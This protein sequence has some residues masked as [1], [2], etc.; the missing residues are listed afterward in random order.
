MNS[1]KRASRV[2]GTMHQS[3]HF[4]VAT[5][6][7]AAEIAAP[8]WVL[9]FPV[10]QNEL[11]GEGSYLVDE[12]SFALVQA[13]FV[14]RGLDLVIDY[15]HQ[16][17]GD[18]PAPAAGWVRELVFDPAA[19]ILARTEWTDRA[20][21][22]LTAREYR[23]FSPVFW[24]DKKTGRL[25]GLHSVALTNTP[26]HNRQLPLVAKH[27]PVEGCMDILKKLAALLG[28]P[29]DATEEAVL[30]AVGGLAEGAGSVPE[31]VSAALGVTERDT[32]TVVA[33]I[34]ALRQSAKCMVSRAEFDALQAQ[35]RGRDAAEAVAKAMGDGKITPEQK[36]WATQYAERDLA[37]F[38]SFVSRAPV[39]VPV[40]KLS[41]PA[42]APADDSPDA[43]TLQVASM[44]GLSSD[45]LKQYGG[46]NA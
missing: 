18:G 45:D 11:E 16:T 29:E 26:K 35:L 42:G 32:S 30:A 43:A 23:Y 39:V 28:L 21:G 10:G 33:S 2:G 34:H 7:G 5:L 19:G 14:R 1:D 13:E 3:M 20:T 36:E 31:A 25:C 44:M 22:H 9:L 15:E 24:V 27:Q 38:A 37:G 40:G 6:G 4:F 17:L 41:A 12:E 8:E 46:Y